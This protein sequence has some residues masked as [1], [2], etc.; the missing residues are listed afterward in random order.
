[1]KSL[2][3]KDPKKLIEN[4][5]KKFNKKKISLYGE[6]IYFRVVSRSRRKSRRSGKRREETAKD[7]E[8]SVFLLNVPKLIQEETLASYLSRFGNVEKIKIKVNK[9]KKFDFGFA[10]FASE[11]M[12]QKAIEAE[13]LD[14]SESLVPMVMK[15]FEPNYKV[16]HEENVKKYQEKV[17]MMKQ[18][19]R[20]EVGMRRRFERRDDAEIVKARNEE[21]KLFSGKIMD[22]ILRISLNIELGS[23][24]FGRNLRLNGGRAENE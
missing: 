19:K 10:S 8:K 14:I 7:P 13:S 2:K 12:A 20:Q 24:H 3:L 6:V 22:Q 23:N 5:V 11:E 18:I 4:I 17:K 16:K 1:M 15:A 9:R 21:M